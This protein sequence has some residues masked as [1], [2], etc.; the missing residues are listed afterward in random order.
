MEV[1][2]Q[3]TELDHMFIAAAHSSYRA[4]KLFHLSSVVL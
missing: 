1:A 2:G 3:V 4:S